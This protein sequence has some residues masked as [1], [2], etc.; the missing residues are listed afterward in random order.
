MQREKIERKGTPQAAIAAADVDGAGATVGGFGVGELLGRAMGIGGAQ[1][2]TP[3]DSSHSEQDWRAES[4][5]ALRVR[6]CTKGLL[7]LP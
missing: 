6:W 5:E 4:R 1:P 2:G 3:T 7:P